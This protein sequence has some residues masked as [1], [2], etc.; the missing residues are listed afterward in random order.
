L[1]VKVAK[2]FVR[3][4]TTDKTNDVG[5][6]ARTE[7]SHSAARTKTA[8]GNTKGVDAKREEEG[9]GAEAKHGGNAGGGNGSR[10]AGRKKGK[11]ER[12]GRGSQVLAEMQN[13]TS[14]G[15]HRARGGMAGTGVANLLPPDG[16]LLIS[17]E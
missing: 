16:V 11:I 6:N 7:K 4:P 15:K 2:H 13:T 17:E 8:G 3:A 5:V 1:Q 9:C 10:F 14:E 12:G